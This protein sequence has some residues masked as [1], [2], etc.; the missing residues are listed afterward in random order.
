MV[1]RKRAGVGT[2]GWGLRRGGPSHQRRL[3]STGVDAIR[4]TWPCQER[5]SLATGRRGRQPGTPCLDGCAT[6]CRPSSRSSGAAGCGGHGRLLAFSIAEWATWIAVVVY[7]FDR[8]GATEAALISMVQ[9]IP[10]LIVAPSAAAFGD[11]FPR[12]RILFGSY[13]L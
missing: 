2:G 4:P 11:R 7:A 12:G 13:L 10:S 9:F 5:A 8:G 1:E 6:V 3:I